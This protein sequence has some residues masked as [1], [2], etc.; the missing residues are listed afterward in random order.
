MGVGDQRVNCKEH[1]ATADDLDGVADEHYA[2]LGHR[3]GKGADKRRESDVGDGEEGF[4][5]RLIGGRS[6]HFAQRG[7]GHDEQGIVGER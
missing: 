6:V 5:Q 3:V 7:N 4:E 2:P 1:H